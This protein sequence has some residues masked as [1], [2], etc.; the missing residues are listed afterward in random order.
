ME[1]YR[2]RPMDFTDATLVRL[3]RRESLATI[4]TVDDDDF[5]TYRI[6]GRRRFPDRAAA[7]R[8]Y[9]TCYTIVD[10]RRVFAIVVHV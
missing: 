6:E 3:A 9:A 8:A 1:R 2:D 4:L 10:L 7:V 5:E